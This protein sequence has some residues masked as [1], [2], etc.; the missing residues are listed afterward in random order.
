MPIEFTHHVSSR[1]RKQQKRKSLNRWFDESDVKKCL[2]YR[3]PSDH[4]RNHLLVRVLLETGARIREIADLTLD[5]V[6]F[7]NN[8][9]WISD[10]KT[11]PRPVF[12]SDDTQS[13][14]ESLFI[15]QKLHPQQG[16][17]GVNEKVKIFPSTNRLKA[18]IHE[19]LVDLKIK[20][21]RDGRG[22]HT[23]R[24]YVATL[25]HYDGGMSLTDLGFLLGDKP[26]TIRDN[27][28]HPTAKMLQAQDGY[29]YEVDVSSDKIS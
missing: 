3:F 22:P 27:Y 11:E 5:R 14:F 9:L 18:I 10:S 7:D 13:I 17:H 16:F 1:E 21:P 24:H 20:T 19:M 26:E 29:G 12:I 28:L 25:L 4:T 2:E 6:D 23:F 15:E 8:T